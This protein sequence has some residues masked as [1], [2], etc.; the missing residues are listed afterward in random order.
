[1][2]VSFTSTPSR[3]NIQSNRLSKETKDATSGRP[4]GSHPVTSQV[5]FVEFNT[6]LPT[7][8]HRSPF[9]FRCYNSSVGSSGTLKNRERNR[10]GGLGPR[11]NRSGAVCDLDAGAVVPAARQQPSGGIRK[12]ED[13]WGLHLGAYHHLLR[14]H[15]NLPYCHRCSYH[16]RLISLHILIFLLVLYLYHFQW[17]HHLSENFWATG[18]NHLSGLGF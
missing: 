9:A 15:H 18:R 1:M 12:H 13:Q 14:T 16:H 11:C 7:C 6:L 4:V 8:P 2:A 5:R 10:D 17:H 3:C